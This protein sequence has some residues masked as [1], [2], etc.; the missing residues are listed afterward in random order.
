MTTDS[1]VV[2]PLFFPGGNIGV[3]AACGTINDLVMQGARPV[4]LTCALIIEEGFSVRSLRTIIRSLAD[5]L[6]P[7]GVAVVTGDT[8]VVER[9]KGSGLFINTTGLG[10][11]L[12][13]QQTGIDN[14][15]P[16]DAVLITGT[17]GDHGI[18]VMNERETLGLKADF[19]SDVA[20]LWK[21]LEP[22]LT[23][24]YEIHCLRDPTRGGLTTALC[25]L[26][27]AS[28]VGVR[29]REDALPIAPITG[30]ACDLLG[31]DPLNV[32]NEGKAIIVCP[33]EQAPAILEQLHAHPL[34]E[35]AAVI[36]NVTSEHPEMA[37]L[38]THIGGQRILRPPAGFDLPRIC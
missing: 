20:P 34:G 19:V 24:D 5:T 9:G 28:R 25:D 30:A 32:A 18:A 35:H 14:A 16:G 22:V 13:G 2:D 26:A 27:T 7:L 37:V 11:R 29:I 3:L 10:M 1:Y 6:E 12:P 17:L 4:A 33:A 15:R 31:L 23:G 36:G 38:E 21:L 8:K